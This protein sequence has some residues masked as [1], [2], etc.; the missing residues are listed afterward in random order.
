V[1]GGGG[2][3][4]LE[5]FLA[6]QNISI[7]W[8]HFDERV[9][10][11]LRFSQSVTQYYVRCSVISR[12]FSEFRLWRNV[13]AGD[14][15]LC[16]HGLP[17]IF[18]LSGR[19]VVFIQNRILL[20]RSVLTKYPLRT[21]L[22]LLMERIWLRTMQKHASQYIVQTPSMASSLKKLLGNKIEIVCLPF[23]ACNT[24]LQKEGSTKSKKI[25]D[26]IYV[27]S[28]DP[29]KNHTKLLEA[30]QLLAE[31]GF[32]PSLALTVDP[33]AYP[34]LSEDIVRISREFSLNIINLGQLSVEDVSSAYQSSSALIYPS[35]TESLGLP[36]IEAMFSGLAIIASEMDYV[37]DV[38]VPVETFDPD[39]PVS[40]ARAVKRFLGNSE[41]TV[42]LQSAEEFLSEVLR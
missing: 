36:L 20:D 11:T 2:L 22:R 31:A 24:L 29:H 7:K 34:A 30:W 8:A 1:H 12:L 17:P 27:A 32:K 23:A 16:F 26:F 19:V 18:P 6:V 35:R 13:L 3:V 40:I 39:S 28:G 38:V 5:E 14:V 4:L 41:P 10:K 33:L 42:Q 37:R 15:V 9:K 21:R 25:F